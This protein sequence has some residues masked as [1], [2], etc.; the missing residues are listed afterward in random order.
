[1]CAK[2]KNDK[3]IDKTVL[4]QKYNQFRKD[5]NYIGMPVSR[6]FEY[7]DF[8]LLLFNLIEFDN[9]LPELEMKRIF[10]ESIKEL[11]E[12]G[13]SDLDKLIGK[14]SKIENSYKNRKTNSFVLLTNI[15]VK[16]SKNINI[17]KLP[18]CTLSFNNYF[19]PEFNNKTLVSEYFPSERLPL[20]YT[21]VKVFTKAKSPIEA[22][23][24]AL[25]G[26]N[27]I[28]G[29]WNLF[30]NGAARSLIHFDDFKLK[31][32][33]YNKILLGPVHT[34]HYPDGRLASDIFWYEINNIYPDRPVDLQR[35][36]SKLK[37][38]EHKIRKLVNKCNYQS[39]LKYAFIK[40]SKALDERNPDN[41]FLQLWS[42]LEFLTNTIKERGY[43]ETVKRTSFFW[44]ERAYHKQ[45]L[46]H[47]R[48]YRNNIA[49]RS[50]S[51]DQN[52]EY[53]FQ[54]ERY[55]ETLLFY[56]IYKGQNFQNFEEACRFLQLPND[57]D[58]VISKI[59][60]Y[61]KVLKYCRL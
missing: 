57:K 46:N 53:V 39:K 55:I 3:K 2:W 42:L 43:D 28:R 15:S 40:Y 27:F 41:R 9:S 16:Y 30:L 18:K 47:L 54:L 60:T 26:I 59:E 8:L 6:W 10:N 1:M 36:W 7:Q 38:F 31:T 44:K 17:I 34:I 14:I 23:N 13:H 32:K 52:Y 48:N 49:H 45:I 61:K 33:P 20:N 19:N 12:K 21:N 25:D 5:S 22:A 50:F 11:K 51:S 4:Q 58:S 29:I 35:Q 56:H 37:T 24:I